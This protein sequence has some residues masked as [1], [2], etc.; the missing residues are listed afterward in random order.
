MLIWWLITGE[1][2]SMGEI[3]SVE[4]EDKM[5]T[6][7]DEVLELRKIKTDVE[8]QLKDINAELESREWELI[9]VMTDKEVDSFK[10]NGVNFIVAT[11]EFRSANPETK[12]ELYLQLRNRGMDY[13]FTV[14]AQTLSAKVKELT[15]D[16]E[17]VLPEWLNGLIN[18]YEKQYISIRKN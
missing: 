12:D 10:R 18:T 3:K 2:Y 16:N 13:L 17:G 15:E 6:L 9:S 14:N 4:N 8:R 7:A 11:K 5:M 1:V